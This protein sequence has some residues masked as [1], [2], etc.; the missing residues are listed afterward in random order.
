MLSRSIILLISLRCGLL[1][2]KAFSVE[3]KDCNSLRKGPTDIACLIKINL[4]GVIALFVF[5]KRVPDILC[6]VSVM[7]WF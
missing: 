3:C 6:A 2:S 1:E 7:V 5:D 4:L